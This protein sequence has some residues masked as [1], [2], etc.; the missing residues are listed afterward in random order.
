MFPGCLKVLRGSTTSKGTLTEISQVKGG[1]LGDAIAILSVTLVDGKI[2][3]VVG[4]PGPDWDP[5]SDPQWLGFSE[6]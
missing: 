2:E 6:D 5:I 3:E 4:K 1:R